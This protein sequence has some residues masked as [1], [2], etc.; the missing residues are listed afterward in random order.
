MKVWLL[1][2]KILKELGYD[3]NTAMNMVIYYI[4][5]KH[6]HIKI[7][8]EEF[9]FDIEKFKKNE[10]IQ[11]SE[12]SLDSKEKKKKDEKLK[13]EKEKKEKKPKIEN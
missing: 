12:P 4:D 9:I 10:T 1:I 13:S 8:D 6:F 7:E 5:N 2:R 11:I 3:S